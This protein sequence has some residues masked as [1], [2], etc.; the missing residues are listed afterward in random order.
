MP[1]KIPTRALFLVFVPVALLLILALW[2]SHEDDDSMSGDAP[3]PR[4]EVGAGRAARELPRD[5]LAG[6]LWGAS[7]QLTGLDEP[8][9]TGDGALETAH[10]GTV[11]GRLLDGKGRAVSGEPVF[12]LRDRDTWESDAPRRDD[13]TPLARLAA[14]TL[15]DAE[16]HFELPAEAGVVHELFAGGRAWARAKLTDVV[17]GDEIDLV[18]RD[19]YVLEGIVRDEQSG[20]PVAGAWVLA[21]SDSS[22]LLGRSGSDG[23]YRLGPLPDLVFLVGGYAQGTGLA[24]RTEVLPALG[25]LP[26]DLP[27]GTPVQGV[28][29][30]ADSGAPIG[31]GEVRLSVDIVAQIAGASEELPDLQAVESQVG[32]VGADGRFA[33]PGGPERGFVLD[34][35]SP[36]YVPEHYDRYKERVLGS[37]T[38]LEIRM[39]R[40]EPVLGTVTV[41]DGGAAAAGARVELHASQGLVATSEADEA[42]AFALDTAAWDGDGELFVHAADAEGRGARGRVGKRE[43]RLLLALVP[44][45][46]VTIEVVQGGLP[47][48]GALVAVRS[49][50]ALTTTA[51]TD[52]E[53][54]AP[55]THVLAGP[56][57]GQG[58]VEA[59]FGSLQSVP[60]EVDLAAPPADPVRVELDAGEWLRG[61][62]TD[63][64]G[65]PVPA[66]R[67]SLRADPRAGSPL[68]LV[69]HTDPQ[70]G[71]EL[72][73]LTPAVTWRLSVS[74]EDH[75][76]KSVGQLAADGD[77]VY[78]ALDPVVS[79]SGR[80]VD[81]VTGKPATN[82][83][84]QLLQ[85]AYDAGQG[86][87]VERNTRERLRHT[88]GVPGDFSFALPGAGRYSIRIVAKDSIPADSLMADTNGIVPPPPVELL[89]WPAG[90]LDVTVQDGRGRAVPG[91]EVTVVPWEL[92]GDGPAPTPKARKAGSI[93]RTDASGVAH[94]SLAKGG[95]FRIAGGA[96]AWLDDTRVPV[97]PGATT[98][99]LYRLPATGDLELTIVDENARPMDGVMVELRSSRD[100][101]S[102]SIYRRTGLRDGDGVVVIETVPPGDY[103]VRLRRRN[104][105]SASHEVQVRANAIERVR[106]AMV[107]RE[108][109]NDSSGAISTSSSRD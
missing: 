23:R 50:G 107:P 63:A 6:A 98:Q 84:G 21:L 28:L 101:K 86:A 30:D 43:Q 42:G 55:V 4:A 40:T 106:L 92:A 33:L 96:G 8:A 90:L 77:P 24:L 56:E 16:G 57:A 38:V 51:R 31:Q 65:V 108:P 2:T 58:I 80:V 19:G 48:V 35:T 83:S 66:A 45:L 62:V 54:R 37:E 70:G 1:S 78:V 15:A 29:V 14:H 100:D 36:G 22:S 68:R 94:F 103:T 102:H 7:V 10:L 93:A 13:P 20:M 11:T 82:F 26:L 88:P 109:S 47:V 76:S 73:P 52:A 95:G 91:F 17:S 64:F 34:V 79:W 89:L 53:G 60:V 3:P 41:A 61:Q 59:R 72:G 99:R 87:T 67:L 74:A 81:A 5:G 69:G 97:Q 104:Y 18:M 71:F 44:P 32:Q 85:H 105:D 25:E 39:R 9:G 46:D 27:P 49:A 75:R 12:L